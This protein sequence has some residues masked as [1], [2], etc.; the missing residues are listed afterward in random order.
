[1]RSLLDIAP[2]SDIEITPDIAT[3]DPLSN[4]PEQTDND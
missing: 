3:Q 1:M 2:D 4:E